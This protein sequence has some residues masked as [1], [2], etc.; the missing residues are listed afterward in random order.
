MA[1]ITVHEF[2][3]VPNSIGEVSWGTNGADVTTPISTPTTHTTATNTR[4]VVITADIKY[5]MA[6][7]SNSAAASG[8]PILAVVPNYF[9]LDGTSAKTLKF[10]AE[11]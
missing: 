7:G 6:F 1:A 11:A 2:Q 5:R 9:Y 3:A 8:I 10:V 4:F